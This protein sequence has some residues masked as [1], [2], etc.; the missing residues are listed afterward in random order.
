MIRC[1]R[2]LKSLLQPGLLVVSAV[3]PLTLPAQGL[4]RQFPQNALRGLL[5]VTTPPNVLINGQS[6]RLSPGARIK[7]VNNLLVMSASLTG[8]AVWV[9]YV[10]DNQGLVHEVWILSA[11]ETQVSR[12]G[13][14]SVRNFTFASEANKPASDD[15]K[16]PYNQLP[17]FPSR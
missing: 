8:Q 13:M 12:A 3:L 7:G 5:E 11:E 17:G 1:I 9:N 16:T 15:G 14:E 10:R 4:Q 6:A 2:L